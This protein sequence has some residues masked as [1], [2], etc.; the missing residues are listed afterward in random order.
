MNEN[1]SINGNLP[2]YEQI[3]Q[4]ILFRIFTGELKSGD[5]LPSIRS[6]AK[7]L[8]VSVITTKRAYDDLEK[9]EFLVT[10]HGLGSYVRELDKELLTDKK[11]KIIQQEAKK[12]VNLCE[13]YSF[14]KDDLIKIINSFD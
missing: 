13:L 6:L 9:D 8:S 3:K 7:Q 5:Q 10:K 12:L 2:I 1:F 11:K 4:Q 14:N